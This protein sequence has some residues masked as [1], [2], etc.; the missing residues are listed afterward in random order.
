[1]RT[2]NIIRF[3]V[4]ALC[5]TIVCIGEWFGVIG[6]G[7]FMTGSYYFF[8]RRSEIATPITAPSIVF[9]VYLTGSVA[10]DIAY[11]RRPESTFRIIFSI[12][13]WITMMVCIYYEW[14]R[15][16]KVAA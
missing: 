11:F 10:V 5:T 9:A 12:V 2:P 6:L 8:I 14:H 13:T 3:V 7:L 15:A 16:N 1:M 4:A